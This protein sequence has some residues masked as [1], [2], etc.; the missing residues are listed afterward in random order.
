MQPDAI[1]Q[2]LFGGGRKLPHFL[3]KLVLQHSA[4]WLRRRRWVCTQIWRSCLSMPCVQ[5]WATLVWATSAT[6]GLLNNWCF[7]VPID[8]Y[9][10]VWS[11]ARTTTRVS[12][13]FFRRQRTFREGTWWHEWISPLKMHKGSWLQ[14]QF[15]YYDFFAPYSI[16]V[17]SSLRSA[18]KKHRKMPSVPTMNLSC[19]KIWPLHPKLTSSY[20]LRKEVPF[21]FFLYL[22]RAD[23]F[24]DHRSIPPLMCQTSSLSRIGLDAGDYCTSTLDLEVNVWKKKMRLTMIDM[25]L[26]ALSFGIADECNMG[27][28]NHERSSIAGNEAVTSARSG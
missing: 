10:I 7:L 6:S 19:K 15:S 1:L 24:I 22:V 26:S 18:E 27:S 16:P 14:R 9:F 12:A 13:A 3:E 4:V 28:F 11:V 2:F 17:F 23:F 8:A 21:W 20:C 25:S 5:F